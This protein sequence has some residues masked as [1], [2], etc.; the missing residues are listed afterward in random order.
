[1]IR[2]TNFC[3]LSLINHENKTISYA[4]E[5][6]KEGIEKQLN[7]KNQISFEDFPW[8]IDQIESKKIIKIEDVNFM[9]EEAMA[10]KE[11][12]LRQG[13]KSMI[14]VPV[15]GDGELLGFIGIDSF[16]ERKKWSE[17]KIKQLNILSNLISHGLIKTKDEKKIEFMAYYDY[18]TVLPNR[19]L[20]KDRIQQALNIA[21]R[22]GTQLG[23]MFID[24]DN[25]KVVNDT[26][27]HKGG[28]FLIKEVA[29]K[30]Q[31]KVRK[32][33]TVARFGGDEFMIM[34]TDIKDEDDVPTIAD[35]IMEMFSQSFKIQEQYFLITASAGISLYPIDGEDAETLV[36]NA[37]TAMYKAK[38]KGKNQFV[39]C[40]TDMK[41]EVET[42]AK[43][44]ND[45]QHA[46]V[47]DEFK[48][49]Y[50]PQ[51][52]IENEKINGVEALIRWFHPDKGMISPGVFI[53]LAEQNGL[54]T[55]IGE[56]VLRTACFQ[57]KKWQDMGLGRLRMAVNLSGIQLLDPKISERVDNI[58][59]ETG[60]EAK[61]LELEITEGTAIKKS[62]HIEEALSRFKELGVAIA[63]D[64][65][66]TEYSSLSR[67]KMLPIDR[68]KIDMQFTQGI[69]SNKKDRAITTIIINLAKSLGLDVLAEGVE[70]IGQGD[71]LK[72][73][74]CDEVQGF[75][76]HKPMPAEEIEKLLRVQQTNREED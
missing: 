6:S 26:I 14:S 52:D 20:F 2:L 44:L 61:Y 40:T 29:Q 54:I 70:T 64:D 56:W 69:E 45:L 23:V 34:L 46:L 57:N 66:G 4:Y 32:T 1:M 76:Y 51:M 42:N 18:L 53:S 73:K 71:F 36:K 8:W 48:V 67:L 16:R 33:D 35:K 28:D 55:T 13:V 31:E 49:Y 37:D 63:I 58:L 60:L 22:N 39:L 72:Q 3:Q 7:I 12:L 17:E 30:L 47:R 21:K 25:F 68:I 65:F 19:F 24:L 74:L 10:E 11:Q 15:E 50:Q 5:Y 27:G 9:P 62:T 75:Y 38:D 43:L 59:E 41:E